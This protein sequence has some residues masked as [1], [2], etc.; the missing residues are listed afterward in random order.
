MKSLSLIVLL[1]FATLAH[2]LPTYSLKEICAAYGNANR[3]K[4]IPFC[5]LK[6]VPGKC[7]LGRGGNPELKGFCEKSSQTSNSCESYSQ[8]NCAW[9]AEA[10]TCDSVRDAL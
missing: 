1:T 8:G 7:T 3:C 5:A 9:K 2:A 4:S 6:A 10:V